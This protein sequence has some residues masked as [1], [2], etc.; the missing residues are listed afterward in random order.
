MYHLSGHI[1]LVLLSLALTLFPRSSETSTE[2]ILPMT[3]A[4]Y[5]I[6]RSLIQRGHVYAATCSNMS[7]ATSVKN[8]S[9]VK[10]NNSFT[11]KKT[12]K[13]KRRTLEKF[14]ALSRRERVV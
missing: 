3:S 5:V 13:K 8:D 9:Q 11:K 14:E 4:A 10:T 2:L 1:K 12:N 6:C 7:A